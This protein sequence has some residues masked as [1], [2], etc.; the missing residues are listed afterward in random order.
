M[1]GE[2]RREKKMEPNLNFKDVGKMMEAFKKCL[3]NGSA[4]C[5]IDE[6]IIFLESEINRMNGRSN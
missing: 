5:Q 2:Q 4:K 3:E 6:S 1:K